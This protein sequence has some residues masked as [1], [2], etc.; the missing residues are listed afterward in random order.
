MHPFACYLYTVK[1]DHFVLAL[2]LALAHEL[3]MDR[4]CVRASGTI[5]I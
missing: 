3:I 2:A 5:T 4:A 1:P